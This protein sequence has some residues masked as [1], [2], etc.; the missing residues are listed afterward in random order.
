MMSDPYIC[1]VHGIET[2]TNYPFHNG[3]V[4]LVIG[5]IQNMPGHVAIALKDG[6]VLF[7]WH[8]ENFRKLKR[9]ET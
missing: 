8:K 5:E 7:G 1:E 6:R 2:S 4:V 3:D 9:S